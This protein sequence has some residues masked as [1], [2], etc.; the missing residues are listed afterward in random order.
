MVGRYFSAVL[1]LITF[2][3]YNAL[4]QSASDVVVQLS[5]DVQTSPPQVKLHW[6]K[7]TGAITYQIFRKTKNA[8]GWGTAVASLPSTDSTYTDNNVVPDSAYEYQVVKQGGSVTAYGYIY[9][10]VRVPAIHNRGALLL[11]V[12]NTFSATCATEL[13]TLMEDL[14]GDGWEVIR[15]D[16]ARTD[17]D[18]AIKS[19]ILKTYAANPRLNAVQIIGHLAVPY[20]GEIAPDGHTPDHVGAWPADVYYADVNGTWTDVSTN[21]SGASRAQNRNIPGD[22]KWDQSNIP[23][24]LELQVGRIDFADMPAFAKTEEQMMKNYLNRA[25]Q[26]KTNAIAIKKRVLI[27]DNFGYFSGEAFAQ[28]GWRLAPIVGRDSLRPG[29]LLTDAN[30][31]SYQWVYACGAGS[32]TSASGVGTT[33][34]VATKNVN[35]I[36]TMMFGSYFGDWDAQNNFLRSVLCADVPALT[37]HW[38]GRPNAFLHHM[39]LGENIGYSIRLSQNNS[40]LYA[41]AN[42]GAQSIHNNL[43]GDLS[44]RTDYF[45]SPGN[46]NLTSSN[47]PKTGAKLTWTAPA[48]PVDGYYVYRSTSEFGN[49]ELRS[50]MV[51]GTSYTDSFGNDGTYYYMVRAVRLQS[52]PSGTYYNTSVGSAKSAMIYYPLSV[53]EVMKSPVLSVFPNPAKDILQLTINS[54]KNEKTGIVICDLS[55]RILLFRL[56]EVLPGNN[57]INL[58]IADLPV[59]AYTLT[60]NTKEGSTTK[61]WIKAE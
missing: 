45:P 30:T 10:G 28:N 39:A 49:Y 36:F 4:A 17:K 46:I 51:T 38:A 7:L 48:G 40:A 23:S 31:D 34:N 19:E 47:N 1:A 54:S 26:Y 14:R 58:F 22:G 43:M 44:L 8:A 42:F 16:F 60:I 59:G 11:L 13:K 2:V 32:Y 37:A 3:T 56:A 52:T 5:A 18:T 15:K 57:T 33:A 29:D 41:P 24:A 20:S 55:G 61:K 27:D 21:N 50:K 9:A 12:D 35:A 25:H 6:K 53:Q